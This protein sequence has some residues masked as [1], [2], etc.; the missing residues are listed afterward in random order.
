MM[1]DLEDVSN[2][3]RGNCNTYKERPDSLSVDE[4]TC[5][6]SKH[7]ENID[8]REHDRNDHEKSLNIESIWYDSDHQSRNSNG[9]GSED[10]IMA[11]TDRE[12]NNN[13][14][15]NSGRHE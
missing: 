9:N 1:M 6:Y 15:K 11:V 13:N 7:T 3:V 8:V 2:H 14:S 5:I 12:G 4:N 10:I